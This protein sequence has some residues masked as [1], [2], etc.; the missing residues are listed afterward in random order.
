LILAAQL[1][2]VE[3][4][5]VFSSLPLKILIASLSLRPSSSSAAR[6]SG[7]TNYP[8]LV[9]GVNPNVAQCQDNHRL[10]DYLLPRLIL[11]FLIGVPNKKGESEGK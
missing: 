1:Y 11:V 9:A 7:R 6:G 4:P 8:R 3:H 5:G 2:K 10:R